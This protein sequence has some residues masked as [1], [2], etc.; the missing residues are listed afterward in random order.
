M[1]SLNLFSHISKTIDIY[2]LLAFILFTKI[3][4]NYV[5]ILR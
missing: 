5:K 1:L 4:V 3:L 2:M